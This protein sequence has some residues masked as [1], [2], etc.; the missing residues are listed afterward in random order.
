MQK[1]AMERVLVS[2]IANMGIANTNRYMMCS[3]RGWTVPEGGISREG[4]REVVM[5]GGSVG[6]RV[7]GRKRGEREGGRGGE[8][9]MERR[10]SVMGV[11]R[12]R[13]KLNA[14]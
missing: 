9:A 10:K 11:R 5:E 4:G 13:L 7:G 6:V 2:M 14:I 8:G 1:A 12:M 3:M